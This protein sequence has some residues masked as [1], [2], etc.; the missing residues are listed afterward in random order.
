MAEGW[1]GSEDVLEKII[2]DAAMK[3]LRDIGETILTTSMNNVPLLS[4]TLRRS[5]TV[6]VGGPVQDPEGVYES[7][8]SPHEAKT[9]RGQSYSGGGQDM[10]DAFREPVGDELRVYVSYNTPY[11]LRQ[12]EDMALAHTEGG[13]KF[14]ENAFNTVTPKIT[15]YVQKQ[16]KA[17][18]ARGG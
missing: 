9:E 5:G 17:A 15:P 1:T 12:H 7:A 2:R 18:L 6:T 14:L 3:A 13:P 11:A 10:K 16:I 8:R 4:G